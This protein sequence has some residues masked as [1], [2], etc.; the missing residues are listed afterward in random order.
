[1][2]SWFLAE[3]KRKACVRR[4]PPGSAESASIM[5]S[6]CVLENEIESVRAE[7]AQCQRSLGDADRRAKTRRRA[8]DNARPTSRRSKRRM[9]LWKRSASKR[10]LVGNARSIRSRTSKSARV[11]RL[12]QAG[13]AG[14]RSWRFAA[15]VRPL[16]RRSRLTKRTAATRRGIREWCALETSVIPERR[17]L[18]ERMEAETKEGFTTGDCGRTAKRHR[19]CEEDDSRNERLLV[20]VSVRRYQV[21]LRLL[22]K[23]RLCAVLRHC[24]RWILISTTRSAA[25]GTTSSMPS[26][27]R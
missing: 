3:R 12:R 4:L 14:M 25:C 10:L 7:S 23:H 15:S 5:E 26:T 16:F 19:R 6:V 24:T 13:N 20:R 17:A 27:G 1:M 11:P 9:S 18:F 2:T 21:S 8:V 22:E